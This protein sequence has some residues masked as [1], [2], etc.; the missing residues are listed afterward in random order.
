MGASTAREETAL[1]AVP[2]RTT[3]GTLDDCYEVAVR[4]LDQANSIA[5]ILY[6]DDSVSVDQ[7]CTVGI[8]GTASD[9][10]RVLEQVVSILERVW[11][12]L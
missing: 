7:P 10:Y 6:C 12:R 1:E 8:Q 11:N 9:T 4:M 5:G 2:H 3:K